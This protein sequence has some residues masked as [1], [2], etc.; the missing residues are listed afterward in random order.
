MDYLDQWIPESDVLRSR[1]TAAP[2]MDNSDLQA[3][4]SE[5]RETG[6]EVRNSC[7][8]IDY[9]RSWVEKVTIDIDKVRRNLR[10]IESVRS[11]YRSSLAH[12]DFATS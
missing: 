8:Y 12:W 5:I 1:F 9:D 4:R 3:D 10:M 7:L 11:G 2:A 6:V